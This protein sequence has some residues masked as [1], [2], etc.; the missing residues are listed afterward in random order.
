MEEISAITLDVGPKLP[1]S[2][3]SV[4]ERPKPLLSVSFVILRSF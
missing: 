2:F 3:G 4:T 1:L